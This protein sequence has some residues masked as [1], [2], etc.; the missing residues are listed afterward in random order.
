MAATQTGPVDVHL[1]QALKD[2]VS[3]LASKFSTD[4]FNCDVS[5]CE[6]TLMPKI[7][8]TASCVE[9]IPEE[10]SCELVVDSTKQQVLDLVLPTLRA[11]GKIR[12]TQVRSMLGNERICLNYDRYFEEIGASRKKINGVTYLVMDA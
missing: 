2:Q 3:A 10:P 11:T 7:V 9:L 8:L 1:F 4:N 6:D 5:L 12:F